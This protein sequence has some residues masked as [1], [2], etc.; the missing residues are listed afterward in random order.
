MPARSIERNKFRRFSGQPDA[1]TGRF[2][3]ATTYIVKKGI[4]LKPFWT[5]LQPGTIQRSSWY[6]KE[7]S[8]PD[9]LALSIETVAL[10][11]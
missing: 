7:G 5:V 11:F 6:R 9:N 4:C 2:L 10:S 1:G 3:P 8:I